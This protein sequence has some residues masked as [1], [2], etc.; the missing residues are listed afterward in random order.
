MSSREESDAKNKRP[1]QA[2]PGI[3]RK[4]EARAQ[5]SGPMGARNFAQFQGA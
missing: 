5:R 4:P 2:L 1:Y 3:Y